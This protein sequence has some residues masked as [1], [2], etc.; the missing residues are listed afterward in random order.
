MRLSLKKQGYAHSTVDQPFP[1]P[2]QGCCT[3]R[4]LALTGEGQWPGL[5]LVFVKKIPLQPVSLYYRLGPQAKTA[6]GYKTNCFSLN[7]D[8]EISVTQ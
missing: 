6:S 1:F 4:A 2:C 5:K 3:H 8:L 7:K